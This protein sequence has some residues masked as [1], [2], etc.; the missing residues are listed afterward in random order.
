MIECDVNIVPMIYI[1]DGTLI[2]TISGDISIECLI[3]FPSILCWLYHNCVE[4]RFVPMI[5]M[6]GS[7]YGC[8]DF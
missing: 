6:T 1:Y 5:N 4:D 3:C 7:C 2:T 8:I